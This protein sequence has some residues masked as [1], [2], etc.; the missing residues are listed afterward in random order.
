MRLLISFFLICTVVAT[1]QNNVDYVDLFIGTAGDHGQLD[2][3]A[4]IPFG[5]I[6]VGPDTEPSNHSG[7]NF[8][9]TRLKGFSINRIS[10]VGCNGAGGNLCIKPL[11]VINKLE[12]VNIVKSTEIASPGYYATSLDNGVFVEMTASRAVAL[13]RYTFPQTAERV[14]SLDLHASFANFFEANFKQISK[15]EISGSEKRSFEFS[16]SKGK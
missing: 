11:T 1:A 14:L 16:F 3:A 9:V 2:P 7:Y 5:Q 6:K 4:T 12:L 15:T 13:Q 8:E 10:G